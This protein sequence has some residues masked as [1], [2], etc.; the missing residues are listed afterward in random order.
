MSREVP[1]PN[2]PLSRKEATAFAKLSERDK[3]AIDAGILSC[4]LPHWQKV[5]MVVGLAENKLTAQFPQFSYILYAKRIHLLAKQGQIES[6]GN[7]RYMRFS[8]VRL[9]VDE[10]IEKVKRER[11]AERLAIAK[12]IAI[13]PGFRPLAT[14]YNPASSTIVASVERHSSDAFERRL[15]FRHV[16]ERT[17]HP[18]PSPSPEIH[19][20]DLITSSTLALI[21]Y[22]VYRVTKDERNGGFSGDW[23]SVDRFDL[24]QR[25]GKT[26]IAKNAIQLPS[27]YTRGWVSQLFGVSQDDSMIFCS[28]GLERPEKGKVHY[29]AC[30][31]EAGSQQVRL[32]SRLEGVWF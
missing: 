11:E 2:P 25:L 9:P 28:C 6:Q 18:V 14:V 1:I 7:L 4:V 15:F 16:S 32:L 21:Y 13:E 31:V 29:W 5:A 23:L 24:T 3:A 17:Y 10:K 27:P 22:L 8:E 26:V 19:Y 12:A 30:T 20:Q